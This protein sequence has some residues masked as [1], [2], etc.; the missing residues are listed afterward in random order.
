MCLALFDADS[1]RRHFEYIKRRSHILNNAAIEQLI[2]YFEKQWIDGSRYFTAED[3]T[4]WNAITR[5]NNDCENWNGTFWRQLTKSRHLYQLATALAKDAKQYISMIDVR[6][7]D[8]Q[9]A[10]Q[11]KK[12][13]EIAQVLDDFENGI[14]R[15]KE[16]LI[17]VVNVTNGI[18]RWD[19]QGDQG[20]PDVD[21]D[22]DY[23]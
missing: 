1:I 21:I 13:D 8:Q 11:K 2:I 6:E 16:A 17:K 23:E 4:T 14:L 5:T 20:D 18:C 12:N 7:P 22:S 19:A 10:S 3:W 9:K 15:P